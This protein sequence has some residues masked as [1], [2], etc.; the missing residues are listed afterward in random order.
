M[1]G[2][3]ATYGQGTGQAPRLAKAGSKLSSQVELL[4]LALARRLTAEP[5][6]QLPALGREVNGHS[7]R[8]FCSLHLAV[9]IYGSNHE[10]R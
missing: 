4:S 1:S 8:M 2:V 10:Q 5:E 7:H 9:S 6:S 3:I